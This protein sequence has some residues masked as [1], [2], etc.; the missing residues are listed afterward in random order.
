MAGGTASADFAVATKKTTPRPSSES[1]APCVVNKC[2]SPPSPAAAAEGTR[3][4]DAMPA[5]S[6]AARR[7]APGL[8][9]EEDEL[10]PE[11][12]SAANSSRSVSSRTAG[13]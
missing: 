10:E 11:R 8:S 9:E 5:S 7:E 4:P 3:T 6:A 2:G 13:V 12:A 1:P